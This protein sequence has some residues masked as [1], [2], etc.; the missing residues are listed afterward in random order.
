M[1]AVFKFIA[2]DKPLIITHTLRNIIGVSNLHFKVERAVKIVLNVNIKA[3]AFAISASFDNLFTFG[4][5]NTINL[6]IENVRL[7]QQ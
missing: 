3:N 6:N 5:R 4:I 7:V 2:V 1:L